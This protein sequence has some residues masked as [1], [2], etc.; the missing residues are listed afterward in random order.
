MSAARRAPHEGF[1][2]PRSGRTALCPHCALRR[3][4]PQRND[5]V[6]GAA[7]GDVARA[8]GGEEEG[9]WTK[10]VSNLPAKSALGSPT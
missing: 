8:A 4:P 2:A 7:A 6:D 10:L 5:C 3:L 9:R 1:P